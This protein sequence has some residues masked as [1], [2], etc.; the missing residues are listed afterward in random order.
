ML[1]MNQ[2][3]QIKDV[4]RRRWGLGLTTRQAAASLG[5]ARSTVAEYIRR[6]EEARLGWPLAEDCDNFVL[7]RRLFPAPP[8]IA[9]ADRPLPDWN[10]VLRDHPKSLSPPLELQLRLSFG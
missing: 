3:D 5:L 4:L 9:A 7:E 8:L 10:E 6:A 2:I 1:R